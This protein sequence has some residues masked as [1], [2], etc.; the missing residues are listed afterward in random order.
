MCVAQ[1]VRRG[2]PGVS[3]RI[4]QRN[5]PLDD[6]QGREPQ[7]AGNSLVFNQGARTL[8]QCKDLDAAQVAALQR[9][10][11]ASPGAFLRAVETPGSCAYIEPSARKTL[12]APVLRALADVVAVPKPRWLSLHLWRNRIG[13]PAFMLFAGPSLLRDLEQLAEDLNVLSNCR[14]LDAARVKRVMTL[15]RK[16]DQKAPLLVSEAAG[17]LPMKLRYAYVVADGIERVLC[18]ISALAVLSDESNALFF[19]ELCAVTERLYLLPPDD[20]T[21]YGVRMPPGQVLF[22]ATKIQHCDA[23]GHKRSLLYYHASPSWNHYLRT[24]RRSFV[25]GRQLFCMCQEC[26]ACGKMLN[27]D[28]RKKCTGCKKACF[29]GPD[30]M[31]AYWP[32]H[33]AECRAEAARLARLSEE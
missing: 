25:N 21:P 19:P 14:E 3:L 27:G 1:A 32:Q 15:L 17:P 22:P 8:I 13:A 4:P 12:G 10:Y 6:C 33:K 29:C 16:P 20:D 11:T 18:T 31:R 2:T 30:C 24:T 7:I 26:D 23:C 28:S 9:M 5:V